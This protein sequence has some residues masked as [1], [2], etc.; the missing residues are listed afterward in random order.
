M[1]TE[2]AGTA[3]W[4]SKYAGKRARSGPGDRKELIEEIIGDW[5][6]LKKM[7]IKEREKYKA[8]TS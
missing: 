4:H 6:L 5:M 8:V 7:E 1:R 3:T 2:I